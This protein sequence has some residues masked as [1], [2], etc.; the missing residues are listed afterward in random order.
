M[1]NFDDPLDDLPILDADGKTIRPERSPPVRSFR[2]TVKQVTQLRRGCNPSPALI[3]PRKEREYH[4][5]L[6]RNRDT[7]AE[8][9]G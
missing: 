5:R 3:M 2:A 4:H 8:I 6:Q 1:P 7:S 9:P